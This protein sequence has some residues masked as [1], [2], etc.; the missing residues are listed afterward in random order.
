MRCNKT[1][2]KA[3]AESVYHYVKKKIFDHKLSW[4][5]LSSCLLT[6]FETLDSVNVWLT[7]TLKSDQLVFSQ[8]KW[9][10]K[11][12]KLYF[13][14]FKINKS[15]CQLWLKSVLFKI[16][17]VKRLF[18]SARSCRA[19]ESVAWMEGSDPAGPSA[20]PVY[21][22]AAKVRQGFFLVREMFFF[23]LDKKSGDILDS[24]NFFTSLLNPHIITFLY[25]VWNKKMSKENI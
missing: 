18:H 22:T 21:E 25:C 3:K 9:V 12:F 5:F 20:W 10:N 13:L 17:A 15:M 2:H 19:G 6:S 23:L 14:S 1:P 7:S 11:R 16:I 8:L 24:Q 4:L